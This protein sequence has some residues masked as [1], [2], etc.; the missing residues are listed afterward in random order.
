LRLRSGRNRGWDHGLVRLEAHDPET[1]DAF[2]ARCLA[3]RQPRGNDD[4]RG[5]RHLSSIKSVEDLLK[6]RKPYIFSLAH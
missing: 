1:L 2:A 3:E 4:P 5:D 6:A